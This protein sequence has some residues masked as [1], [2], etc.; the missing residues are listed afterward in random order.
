VTDAVLTVTAPAT[1]DLGD[2]RLI[3]PPPASPRLVSLRSAANAAPPYV[4]TLN[5]PTAIGSTLVVT[6][7]GSTGQQATAIS[8]SLGRTW[9]VI[10]G[11]GTAATNWMGWIYQ[12]SA[13]LG[14]GGTVSV[15]MSGTG[16]GQA[17]VMELP[18]YTGPDQISTAGSGTNSLTWPVPATPPISSVPQ[19]ALATVAASVATA[20]V[21]VPPGWTPISPQGGITQYSEA[22]YLMLNDIGPAGPITWIT[23]P[24]VGTFS[25]IVAT[26]AHPPVAKPPPPTPLPLIINQAVTI[27]DPRLIPAPPIV[28]AFTRILQPGDINDPVA[29][30][31]A[32]PGQAIGFWGVGLWSGDMMS[33]MLV[34]GNPAEF[35]AGG[36]SRELE[37]WCWAAIGDGGPGFVTLTAQHPDG[38][39]VVANTFQRLPS[40]A[41][42]LSMSV[43]DQSHLTVTVSVV[44]DNTGGPAWPGPTTVWW[45]DGTSSLQD[46][47]LWAAQHT[48]DPSILW[49]QPQRSFAVGATADGFGFGL[50]WISVS[51]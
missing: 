27:G 24:T 37:D 46:D 1:V 5:T 51:A 49:D 47:M 25:A 34:D 41:D 32:M 11:I 13:A 4:A 31:E 16:G 21:T 6:G 12:A 19:V 48:Y 9:T 17:F 36:Q 38:D 3:S 30:A 14:V 43:I 22:A 33:G 29:G 23:T 20:N 26:F 35:W 44:T 42:S 28:P 10:T 15:T 45:G 18:G 39:V 40:D 8:D 50:M 7:R 2:A